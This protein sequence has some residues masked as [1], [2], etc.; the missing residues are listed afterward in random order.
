MSQRPGALLLGGPG[1]QQ[2]LEEK[3]LM[4]KILHDPKD[5]KL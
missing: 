4:D 3:R 5:S 1:K 2:K